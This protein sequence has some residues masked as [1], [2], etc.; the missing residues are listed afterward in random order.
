MAWHLGIHLALSP[1]RHPRE[2]LGNGGDS[3]LPL[4]PFGLCLNISG[5]LG[6]LEPP[7]HLKHILNHSWAKAQCFGA[8]PGIRSS[9]S[10]SDTAAELNSFA[11]AALGRLRVLGFPGLCAN[12]TVPP[13]R[14]P[15]GDGKQGIWGR[16]SALPF[17]CVCTRLLRGTTPSHWARSGHGGSLGE[18]VKVNFTTCTERG[19]LASLFLNSHEITIAIAKVSE[20]KKKKKFCQSLKSFCNNSCRRFSKLAA[21]LNLYMQAQGL[22]L[23]KW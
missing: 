15:E 19:P 11:K 13:G 4:L 21:S 17:V 23:C 2:T 9:Y 20:T 18:D 7:H 8:F 22:W 10:G 1:Q 12:E 6:L 14:K 16:I 3:T 5:N